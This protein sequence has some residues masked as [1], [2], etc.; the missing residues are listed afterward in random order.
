MSALQG[1]WHRLRPVV[2]RGAY[3][4]EMAEE[5]RFHQ[6]LDARDHGAD[7]AT[8]RFGNVTYIKEEVR[9]MSWLALMDTFAQDVRF[10]VR[11]FARRPA[12][13][14]A[15][16]ATIALGIGAATAI[17]SVADGVL[18]R[19]LPF[20]HSDQLV[21]VWRTRPEVRMLPEMADRWD[22]GTISLPEYRDW[23]AAQQSFSDVAVFTGINLSIT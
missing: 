9:R 21:T 16:L 5:M 17:Y 7:A 23:S 11:T 12:F 14:T 10:A 20:P 8:R 3:D 2:R 4:R 6:E 18:F 19:P 22:H 13:T 15:A 1:W